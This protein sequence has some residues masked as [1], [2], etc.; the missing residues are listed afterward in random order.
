MA[1]ALVFSAPWI[2]ARRGRHYLETLLPRLGF[3]TAA[4]GSEAKT[5][6]TGALWIHAVSVG[7]VGVAETLLGELPDG[8]PVVVTT[9]TPTGQERA[10]KAFAGRGSVTYFPFELGFA[11]ASFFRRFE[12]RALVLVEGDLWPLVLRAA[13]SRGLPVLVVNG[14]VSDRSFPRLTRFRRFLGPLYRPVDRFGMQTA[15]DRDRL[16]ALGVPPEKVW[17]TG[18]LKYESAEPTSNPQLE[19]RLL[20]VAQGRPLLV[21]GSTMVGEEEAVLEAFSTLL[22][23][24]EAL[25]I[26][27]PRHPERWSEVFRRLEATGLV[28]VRRSRFDQA[29]SGP[30]PQVVLLDSLG[31]LAGLY[32]IAASAFIGGTLV[33]TGG[34]N[35]LE[36]ARYGV[37]IVVG[38]SMENFREM[39]QHFDQAEAW[40]RVSS[41]KELAAVWRHWLEHPEKA[42]EVGRRAS[43]LLESHRGALAATLEV[44]EPV[45]KLFPAQEVVMRP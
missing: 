16:L 43:Q 2:L 39:A 36:P 31:E 20:E 5:P 37:P 30:R 34:H 45:L 4:C 8:L 29:S 22:E 12:P 19:S 44:M 38:P 17:V 1:V 18:N 11:V 23:S 7:E 42:T 24:Q 13:R 35:A 32:R 15:A 14:R 21:A 40:S 33:P 6:P 26:L 10:R 3:S 41:S 27:V 9:I 25:L 28:V